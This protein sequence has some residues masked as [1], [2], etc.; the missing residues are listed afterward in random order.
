MPIPKIQS[1]NVLI[2]PHLATTPKNTK[3][4][5][6]AEYGSGKSGDS[7]LCLTDCRDQ[8][9]KTSHHQVQISELYFPH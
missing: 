3:E 8:R 9:E 6:K 7:Q 5:W 4:A 1:L 2:Y